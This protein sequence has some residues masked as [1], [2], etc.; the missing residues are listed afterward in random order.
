METTLITA[1]S[2]LPL[3]PA[4]AEILDFW[5]GTTDLAA[6]AAEGRARM[7]FAGGA[8]LDASIRERFGARVDSALAG[9][10]DDWAETP[11]GRLALIILLDQFTRNISRGS[12]LAF[13]GDP[14][15]Q[16][17]T[18]A[19]VGA[20]EHAAM[21]LDQKLFLFTPLE[22]AEDLALQDQ[23]VAL[24][25]DACAGEDG[26]LA[27]KYLRYAVIHR[28]LIARFGRFPH[29]N[30]I[31]SREHTPE[32]EAHLSGGGETFGQGG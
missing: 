12:P 3:H 28:D 13:A 26:E 7:W 11:A 4:A 21:G 10:L 19:A 32:E 15:A 9:D 14:E 2:P 22:H 18:L 16:A 17:L 24:F 30:P 27:Q 8:D 23:C 29:R 31:L 5:F 20:G 1:G 6:P 25:E